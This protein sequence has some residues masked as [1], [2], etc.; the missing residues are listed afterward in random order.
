MSHVIRPQN[1]QYRKLVG[2]L[3]WQ[4]VI[5]DIKHQHLLIW[6]G[7]EARGGDVSPEAEREPPACLKRPTFSDRGCS[8]LCVTAQRWIH[9]GANKTTERGGGGGGDLERAGGHVSRPRIMF[10]LFCQTEMCVL[11]VNSQESCTHTHSYSIVNINN[12]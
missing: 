8:L 10:S 6:G 1:C 4:L 11:T 9:K 5:G 3:N 12:T 2:D 7:A